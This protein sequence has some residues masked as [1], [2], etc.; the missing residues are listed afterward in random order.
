MSI[1]SK[2]ESL[3]LSKLAGLKLSENEAALVVEIV[4]IKKDYNDNPYQKTSKSVE[5]VE[6]GY[7]GNLSCCPY[8]GQCMGCGSCG[9]VC[10]N[11]KPKQPGP[12]VPQDKNLGE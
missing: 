12:E 9:L 1:C 11:E 10:N 5:G 3:N 2:G 8:P 4:G 6:C 7:C